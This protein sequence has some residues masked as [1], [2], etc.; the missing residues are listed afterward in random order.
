MLGER[1][2]K[3]LLE[4]AACR[5]SITRENTN[6]T[7]FATRIALRIPSSPPFPRVN[8]LSFHIDPGFFRPQAGHTGADLLTNLLQLGQRSALFFDEFIEV[9]NYL[10][11]SMVSMVGMAG[12]L[13][14]GSKD[15]NSSSGALHHMSDS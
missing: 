7:I 13:Q 14:S 12:T 9:S 2:F 10:N 1:K 6:S 11:I 5:R 8:I 4:K 15:N 3:G